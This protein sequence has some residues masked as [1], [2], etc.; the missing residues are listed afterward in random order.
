MGDSTAAVQYQWLQGED[1]PCCP[2]GI[3]QVRFQIG[4]DGSLQALDPIPGP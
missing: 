4:D 3:G 2:T 1:N